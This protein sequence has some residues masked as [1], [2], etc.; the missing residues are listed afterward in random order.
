MNR[1]TGPIPQNVPV[2]TAAVMAATT[3]NA[4]DLTIANVA[5]PHMQ[6][7][8]SAS[9]DQIT[10]VL[11]SY[12]VAAAIM[13]PMSGWLAGRF[14]RKNLMRVS[15]MGFVL[16]SVFCGTAT[17]LGELVGFRL[18]QGLFGAALVPMSQAILLDINPPERHGQA[19]AVWVMGAM[20]GPIMGPSLGG[21]LTE[22]LSWRWVFFINIPVGLAA[23]VGMSFL[24]EGERIERP[25]LDI[26]GFAMLALAIG[27]LQLMLDRGQ[28]LDWFSS[29]EIRFEAVAAVTCFI[30]F[31]IQM[32]L[33]DAPFIDLALFADRN[34]LFGCIFAFF[35]GIL[36]FA[37]LSL[38][39]PLLE[40][41]MGY[42]VLFTGLVTMPRGLGSLITM[43]LVGRI[44]HRVDPRLLMLIGMV[45]SSIA[46]RSMAGFSLQMD[47]RLV[48]VSGFIQ[49]LGIGLVFVPL[50]T[51]AYATLDARFRNE[52]A[53][54]YTLI[55]N[56]GAA[57][58]IAV[59]S[60]MNIRNSETVHARLVEGLRPDNPAVH[61]ALSSLDFTD[62]ASM[63]ALN[64]QVNAQAGMVSYV[65]AFWVL[66]IGAL[67]LTPLILLM[68][69]PRRAA[70]VKAKG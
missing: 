28:Q 52:G 2:I 54:M 21:F 50:S 24:R 43:T 61:N 67:A 17:T 68:R 4:L 62:R 42:P 57:V 59:L 40:H 55:R 45:L 48:A 51:L 44:I 47:Y 36:M 35:L 8:V 19:M 64:A 53:A 9:A 30:M 22:N 11:T 23:F 5:L 49:G 20:L 70:A 65:D 18:L 3:M 33:A 63:V 38:L 39:P 66:F 58:G 6:G 25:R 31:L 7:S 27:S 69:A 46:M 37:T 13:T 26:L 16:A 41:L 14:G 34:F 29:W 56:T 12:I 60:A 15:M 10:W 32:R 1:P